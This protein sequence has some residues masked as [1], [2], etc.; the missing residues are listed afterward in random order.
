MNEAATPEFEET[1]FGQDPT[2]SEPDALPGTTRWELPALSPR[3]MPAY[4]LIWAALFLTALVMTGLTLKNTHW[5]GPERLP[6]LRVGINYTRDATPYL[7]VW[8]VPG[9]R[10]RLA[11]IRPGDHIVELMDS[12]NLDDALGAVVDAPNNIPVP[13]RVQH[14]DGTTLRATLATSPR[15][16]AAALAGVGLSAPL[17]QTWTRLILGLGS[18]IVL[19]ASALLYRQRQNPVAAL[20]S[21][22]SLVAVASPTGIVGYDWALVAAAVAIALT[23]IATL[24]FPD[25]RFATLP[26]RILVIGNVIWFGVF[27]VRSIFTRKGS[28]PPSRSARLRSSRAIA[29][30]AT[31]PTGNS[32]AGQHWVLQA[33]HC[34]PPRPP[35]CPPSPTGSTGCS[36]LSP[37]TCR[38]M[39]STWAIRCVCGAAS[40][41]HCCASGC[42]TPT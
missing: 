18:A 32:S 4:R 25:G 6:L 20:L 8:E 29:A 24:A 17:M 2:A 34:S 42:T 21:V 16:V 36:T 15:E 40:A 26:S 28:I 37:T 10:A 27:F 9:K 22:S 41:S 1:A 33:P 14:S 23:N 31:P 19:I 11:G 3:L 13:I 38:P 35:S 39:R 12:R 30:R 5:D 7:L